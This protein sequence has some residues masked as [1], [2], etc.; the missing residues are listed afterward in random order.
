MD[1]VSW[2]IR[3]SK[4][5]VGRYSALALLSMRV[6]LRMFCY[7]STSSRA[8][9][10]DKLYVASQKLAKCLYAEGRQSFQVMH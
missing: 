9:Y 4:L 2:Q 6:S 3:C 8:Y 7:S 5:E 10:G 1:G